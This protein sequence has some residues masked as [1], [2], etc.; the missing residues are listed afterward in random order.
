NRDPF[1][2]MLAAQAE[3]EHLVL[4]SADPQLASFPCQILW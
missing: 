2:R 3:L 4:L 1:D